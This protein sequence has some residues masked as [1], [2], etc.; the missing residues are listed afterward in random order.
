MLAEKPIVYTDG[1]GISE[2]LEFRKVAVAADLAEFMS[3]N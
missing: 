2:F 1:I 3:K